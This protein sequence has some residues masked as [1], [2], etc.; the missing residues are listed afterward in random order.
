M[1]DWGL[2]RA[3][4]SYAQTMLPSRSA[5]LTTQMVGRA[6]RMPRA[7]VEPEDQ[8]E[9]YAATAAEVARGF[10]LPEPGPLVFDLAPDDGRMVTLSGLDELDR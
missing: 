10:S 4:G 2:P 6:L 8:D 3:D 5:A 7:A 1:A 9:V